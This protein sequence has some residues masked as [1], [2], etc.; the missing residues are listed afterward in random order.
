MAMSSVLQRNGD[1]L[2]DSWEPQ[3]QRA[4][5]PTVPRPP[6][7]GVCGRRG[8][9]RRREPE[10]AGGLLAGARAAHRDAGHGLVERAAVLAR[11]DAEV[12]QRLHVFAVKGPALGEIEGRI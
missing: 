6:G 12:V 2:V 10:T 11:G 3:G 5:R 4:N 1:V 9:L 7:V 8:N